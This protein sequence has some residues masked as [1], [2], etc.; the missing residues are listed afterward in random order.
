MRFA[1]AASTQP[2]RELAIPN[3]G[4]TLGAAGEWMGA[5]LGT[6]RVLCCPKPESAR[7]PIARRD[8]LLRLPPGPTRLVRMRNIGRECSSGAE[9]RSANSDSLENM[10]LELLDLASF[11]AAARAE[12]ARHPRADCARPPALQ[13]AHLSR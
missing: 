11:L 12:T 5:A 6:P 8:G 10:E 1:S 7:L 9:N 4:P 3:E 13:T 2:E